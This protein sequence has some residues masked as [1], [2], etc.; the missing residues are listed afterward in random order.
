MHSL[1]KVK[2]EPYKDSRGYISKNFGVQ[3]QEACQ[4]ILS[5]VEDQV[6]S[7]ML[8]SSEGSLLHT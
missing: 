5:K 8:S 4:Q 3:W 2:D 6:E 1:Q 7:P